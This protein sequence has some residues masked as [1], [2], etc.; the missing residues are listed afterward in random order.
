MISISVIVILIGAWILIPTYYSYYINT[1]RNR[2][3]EMFAFRHEFSY[4]FKD[5]QNIFLQYKDH[6]TFSRGTWWKA[7]NISRGEQENLKICTF[8][9]Q[10]TVASGKRYRENFVYTLVTI[11]VPIVFKVLYIR[12]EGFVDKL[13][14]SFGFE[15]INFESAEFSKKYFVKCEDKKFAYDIIHTRMMEFLLKCN[16]MT[17]EAQDRIVVFHRNKKLPDSDLEELLIELINFIKMI[18]EYIK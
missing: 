13:K 5:T 6:F 1:K 7:Y 16:P 12:P 9:F 18:P 10:F 11:E 3:W 8:D 14:G 17:I 2:E 4:E 15:D